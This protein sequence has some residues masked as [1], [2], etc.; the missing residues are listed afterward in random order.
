[1]SVPHPLPSW[2]PVVALEHRS[3]SCIVIGLRLLDRRSTLTQCPHELAMSDE[4]FLLEPAAVADEMVFPAPRATPHRVPFDQV[5]A[6]LE[7]GSAASTMGRAH[8]RLSHM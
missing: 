8:G 6:I 5:R 4:P 3:P 1:M 2:I 7:L